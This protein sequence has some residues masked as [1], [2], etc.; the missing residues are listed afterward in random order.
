MQQERVSELKIKVEKDFARME[1]DFARVEK[2]FA[3][4]DKE[5]RCLKLGIGLIGFVM[6][7]V[8]LLVVSV[9]K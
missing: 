3:R 1:K 5:I 8:F 7:F 2:D 6:L 9:L 4:V